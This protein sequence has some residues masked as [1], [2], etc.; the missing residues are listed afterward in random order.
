MKWK[1]MRKS[2]D[3][4]RCMCVF[5]FGNNN[6]NNNRQIMGW[7]VKSMKYEPWEI[8]PECVWMGH[9]VV[10]GCPFIAK[11]RLINESCPTALIACVC[12][13]FLV[14]LTC[15]AKQKYFMVKIKKKYIYCELKYF[16]MDARNHCT[17]VVK[18]IKKITKTLQNF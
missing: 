1:W 2:F 11:E 3:W 14:D 7:N 18:S 8:R 6:N 9:S 4:G 5:S 10:L 16:T 12:S 15:V 17:S 13:T